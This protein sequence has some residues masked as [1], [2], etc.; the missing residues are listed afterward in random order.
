[1]TKVKNTYYHVR[2]MKCD[3]INKLRFGGSA[4]PSPYTN[5]EIYVLISNQMESA[6]FTDYCHTCQLETMNMFVAWED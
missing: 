1:M 3:K 4:T 6:T 5:D 2:C